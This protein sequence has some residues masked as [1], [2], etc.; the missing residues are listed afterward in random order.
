MKAI[1]R[2]IG[3]ALLA[4]IS[5]G[6]SEIDLER[7]RGS[8]SLHASH[9]QYA[10]ITR[11]CDG[12]VTKEDIPFTEYGLNVDWTNQSRFALK[13]STEIVEF[14]DVHSDDPFA[15]DTKAMVFIP[16]IGVDGEVVGCRFGVFKSTKSLPEIDTNKVLPAFHFR[17][18]K[19]EKFHFDISWLDDA[20]VISRGYLTIGFGTGPNEKGSFWMGISGGPFDKLGILLQ[21]GIPISSRISLDVGARIGS[22]E[23]VGEHALN[24]GMGYHFG[25]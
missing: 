12:S 5:L 25:G 4:S 2:F 13:F 3:L 23:G 8:V 22:S 18:G 19:R 24:A 10:H 21:A 15:E 14:K 7:G 1:G 11:G 6:F 9:G 20:P 17:L 16:Q